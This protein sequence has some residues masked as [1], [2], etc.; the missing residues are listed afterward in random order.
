[1]GQL[2]D[3]QLQKA[4]G[5]V[6]LQLLPWK[7]PVVERGLELLA[8]GLDLGRTQIHT[9]R[10]LML[11]AVT[12]GW[13]LMNNVGNQAAQLQSLPFYNTSVTVAAKY[14]NQP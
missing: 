11:T 12:T 1:M 13:W 4:S 9:G 3:E 5:I 6:L 2:P 10:S 8:Q 14:F 7:H